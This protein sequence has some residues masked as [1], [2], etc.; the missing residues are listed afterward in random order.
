MSGYTPYPQS[1]Q[2]NWAPSGERGYLQGAPVD[3]P[4]EAVSQAFKNVFNYNGRASRSAFWWFYLLTVIVNGIFRSLPNNLIIDV[5]GG[6]IG[7]VLFL[8]A[9]AAAA[10]R[11]HD[12]DRSALWLFLILFI[13]I[14]WIWLLVYYCQPGTE[15]PNK[16]DVQPWQGQTPPPAPYGQQPPAGY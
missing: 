8:T 14:G 9:L 7:I 5:I 12:T 2:G 15:G 10:R 1:P 16:Y 4:I 13:I 6:L 11:L 3:S